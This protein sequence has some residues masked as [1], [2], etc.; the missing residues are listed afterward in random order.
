[1]STEYLFGPLERR[2]VFL[3]A[4]LGQIVVVLIGTGL[5]V[6]I[7]T[8]WPS[9]LGAALGVCV[10]AGGG[11]VI[12]V[13][14]AGRTVDEWAPVLAAF[15]R[16][17]LS[18]TDRW[19]SSGNLHGHRLRPIAGWS[20]HGVVDP[21]LRTRRTPPLHVVRAPVGGRVPEERD[22]DLGGP[23]NSIVREVRRLDSDETAPPYLRGIQLLAARWSDGE[24]GVIADARGR[25]YTAVIAVG[26]SS[27]S[28]DDG[29][30][31]EQR[32]GQWGAVL[33]GIARDASS[34]VI[35][36]QWLERTTPNDSEA[37]IRDLQQHRVVDVS[38][39]FVRSYLSLLDEHGPHT[40]RHEVHL[41]VQVSAARASAT[42]RRRRAGVDIGACE[43]LSEEL[44]ALAHRLRQAD[45]EV[46]GVLSP[47]MLAATVRHAA[48]P[49]AREQLICRAPVD[50]D[51]AGASPRNALPR[52]S[53]ASWSS[54]QTES[55]HHATYW[56]AEWPRTTV[57]TDWMSPLLLGTRS[58]RTVSV[59]M[60]PSP[61]GRALRRV[62]AARVDDETTASFRQ[63]FGFRRTV[64]RQREAENVARAE[65][66]L[67]EGHQHLAVSA[68]VTVTASSVAELAVACQEI[69]Q[70]AGL[71]RLDVRRE[72]GSQDVAFTYSLPLCRGLR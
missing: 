46:R 10:V 67:N 11:V 60:E 65:E 34:A 53:L 2:G 24:V 3:G 28:L 27:P 19:I 61:P 35:R 17:R 43:A 15:L 47:R 44:V 4:R 56:V 22:R 14:V 62:E 18:G 5:V 66:E 13:P 36:L 71:S 68:Y 32:F 26:A 9:P 54:F 45:I 33:A 21:Q 69:E 59:V 29:G 12:L 50:P 42:I 58:R 7:L 20:G 39:P 38:N 63:R 49:G 72:Y 41:A 64:R 57:G 8:V 25:T 16:A 30:E 48:D 40:Q 31:K 70:Q 52:R 1:M 51:S 6:G 37:A 55:A 23:A